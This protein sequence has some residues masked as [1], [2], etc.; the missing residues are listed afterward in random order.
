M[1]GDELRFGRMW[2]RSPEMQ[3][4]FRR[5]REIAQTDTSVIVE[6]ET[7]TGKEL[8]GEAIHEHSQRA[9]KPY[10]V[11]DCAAVP[12][13]LIESELFGHVRGAFT[14]ALAD[15]K[16]AFEAAD[17]G[18]IFIDEIGELPTGL[19]PRLLRVLERQEVKRVGANAT[20]TVDTRIVAATNRDL[21]REVQEG[22]FR[23]D[24]YFRLAVVKVKIPALRERR[25]DI[26]FL[27]ERFLS[28]IPTMSGKPLEL[29]QDAK[30]RLLDYDWPGNV[31]EL[32]NIIDR[33]AAMSDRYFRIP[34]DFG[35]SVDLDG[36]DGLAPGSGVGIHDDYEMSAADL[37]LVKSAAAGNVG[38]LT[39]PL[40]Q[41]KSYKDAKAAVMADFERGYI[42]AL[43]EEHNGNVSA[44]ARAAGI[45][46]N[47]LHRM[48]ARYGI[49]R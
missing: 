45:H 3:T 22:R 5:L 35:Q 18:T 31:R 23:E 29:R 48:M 26:L 10:I 7:G 28:E 9:D 49:G 36:A 42:A 16:G 47:I 6:G 1:T 43:L 15:R 19:Q 4:V 39:K 40:W 32:K 11:V 13:E 38:Q 30:D 46:R 20:K 14:S 41:G 27:A 12:S 34:D 17:S 37:E 24:L 8:V 33:G 21:Q 2:G 44:A 25:D